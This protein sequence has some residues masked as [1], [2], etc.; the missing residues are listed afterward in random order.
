[1]R[2]M[3]TFPEQTEQWILRIFKQRLLISSRVL[4][5]KAQLEH[6]TDQTGRGFKAKRNVTGIWK[7]RKSNTR[8]LDINIETKNS[9]WMVFCSFFFFY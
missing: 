7:A 8:R 2:Q 6:E 3:K 4:E 1:M 9:K 5:N